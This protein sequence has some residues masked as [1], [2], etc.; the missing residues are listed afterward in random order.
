METIELNSALFG[1]TM[2]EPNSYVLMDGDF[3]GNELGSDLS[4]MDVPLRDP[5]RPYWLPPDEYGLIVD[6]KKQLRFLCECWWDT[7]NDY[8]NEC[9]RVPALEGAFDLGTPKLDTIFS[10]REYNFLSDSVDFDLTVDKEKLFAFC[11]EHKEDFEAVLAHH[12]SYDGFHSFFP[13]SFEAW[14]TEETEWKRISQATEFAIIYAKSYINEENSCYDTGEE[15]VKHLNEE[16]YRDFMNH[17]RENY[18]C[19]DYLSEQ[20]FSEAE[21]VMHDGLLCEKTFNRYRN[22]ECFDPAP[23]Y[24]VFWAVCTQSLDVKDYA[25][26]E[27]YQTALSEGRLAKWVETLDNKEEFFNALAEFY[28]N[29]EHFT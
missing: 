15:K 12:A 10:P 27:T 26:A 9:E 2:C 23:S 13:S 28:K 22:E 18:F 11:E 17:W 21:L 8:L 6:G 3:D 5:K 16:F 4:G 29:C 7:F 24:Q 19:G 20:D 25:K 14:Q 1:H